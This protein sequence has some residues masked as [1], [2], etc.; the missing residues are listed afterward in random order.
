MYMRI[1]IDGE[2]FQHIYWIPD[3]E[4]KIPKFGK[5]IPKS[6]CESAPIIG[7]TAFECIAHYNKLTDTARSGHPLTTSAEALLCPGRPLSMK[8]ARQTKQRRVRLVVLNTLKRA[9]RCW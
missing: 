1:Q 8:L 7:N 9:K 6:W 3:Q 2:Y 5:F 4:S